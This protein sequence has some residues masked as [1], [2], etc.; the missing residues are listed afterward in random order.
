MFIVSE[1]TLGTIATGYIFGLFAVYIIRR[2]LPGSF[3]LR[4]MYWFIKLILVF[5]WEMIKANIE[6]IRLILSPKVDIH[7]GFFAYPCDL[8]E[9]WEVSLLSALISLTPG[10]ILVA[11]SDDYS[12]L[13]IH[14]IDL[15]DADEEIENIRANFENVIKEVAKP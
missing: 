2:F 12:T 1:F 14:A 9:D 6:L 13:Y 15:K 11:I 8:E 4:R 10:T 5:I 7:P 3:Y